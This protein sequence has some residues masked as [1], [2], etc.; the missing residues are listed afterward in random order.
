MGGKGKGF[1]V[2]KA[3]RIDVDKEKQR[4]LRSSC[5]TGREQERKLVE[6]NPLD[7]GRNKK[8]AEK[9]RDIFQLLGG[10]Q[11]E[12]PMRSLTATGLLRTGGSTE[13][14]QCGRATLGTVLCM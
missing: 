6:P 7:V 11:P 8:E 14:W 1:P 3:V 9:K 2:E 5:G 13:E 4:L 10:F 12:P